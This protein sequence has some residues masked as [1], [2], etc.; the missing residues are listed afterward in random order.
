MSREPEFQAALDREVDWLAVMRA[1]DWKDLSDSYTAAAKAA[2]E[3]AEQVQHIAEVFDAE[4]TVERV[5]RMRAEVRE[6]SERGLSKVAKLP[7]QTVYVRGGN[8]VVRRS[9]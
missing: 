6:A 3:F 5:A 8:F 7:P 9:R 4:S 1:F 2:N